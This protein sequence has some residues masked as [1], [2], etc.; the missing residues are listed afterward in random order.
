MSRHTTS[1]MRW[2]KDKHV[3]IDGILRHPIDSEVGWTLKTNILIL[4]KIQAML[5]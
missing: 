4:L 5:D 3:E 1:D 2:H